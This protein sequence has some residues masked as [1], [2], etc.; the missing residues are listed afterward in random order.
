MK[1]RKS[2]CAGEGDENVRGWE[3]EWVQAVQ[4]AGLIRVCTACVCVFVCICG[5]G[6]LQSE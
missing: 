2:D 5:Q 4:L 6:A 1:W 3:T